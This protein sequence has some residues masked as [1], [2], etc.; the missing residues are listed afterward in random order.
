MM[1]MFPKKK[2]SFEKYVFTSTIFLIDIF[3][4][5]HFLKP[6]ISKDDAQF[7][8]TRQYISSQNTIISFWNIDF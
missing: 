3:W 2:I 7:L 4:Q 8:T 6:Y 1:Q 5:L